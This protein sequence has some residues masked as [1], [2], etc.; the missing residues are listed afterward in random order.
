MPSRAIA[1]RPRSQSGSSRPASSG[2][3]VSTTRRTWPT[4][5]CGNK[6][7]RACRSNDTAP[8]ASSNS[9][10]AAD[11]MTPALIARSSFPRPSPPPP[12]IRRPV[13]SARIR[14]CRRSGCVLTTTGL[15][16]RAVAFHEIRLYSSPCTYARRLS[17]SLPRS[18]ARAWRMPPARRPDGSS[19]SSRSCRTSGQVTA[20]TAVPGN[21]RW[22]KASRRGPST[23]A[24]TAGKAVGPRRRGTSSSGTVASCPAA[25]VSSWSSGRRPALAGGASARCTTTG[26]RALV[27]T[28]SSIAFTRPIEN[29]P[30][31]TRSTA[32]GVA[33]ASRQSQATRPRAAAVAT[34]NTG[35]DAPAG[36]ASSV[37]SAA[38]PNGARPRGVITAA[39]RPLRSPHRPRRRPGVRS[40]RRRQ[41]GRSGAA[42]RRGRAPARRRA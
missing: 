11:S 19:R 31:E 24:P 42:S 26:R 35:P 16:R 33:L 39:R 40:A 1:A 32:S 4:R 20:T 10:A 28:T 13:S 38:T 21:L 41:T 9:R 25:M 17:N 12:A 7:P 29:G 8:T 15:P 37:S 27:D 2:A 5:A 30:G 14:D 36:A 34:A 22:L 6:A 3:S 18:P 23:R